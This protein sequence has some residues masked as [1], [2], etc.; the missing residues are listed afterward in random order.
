MAREV[1]RWTPETTWGTFDALATPIIIQLDQ[2]NQFTM[3]KK[4]VEW[5]IRSAGGYNRRVQKGSAKYLLQGA[6]N[7][8]VFDTQLAT[9]APAL[10]ASTSNTLGSAT[11]DHFAVME[12][13]G[14]TKWYGRYLGVM[15]PQVGVAAK[16]S[17]QLMRLTLQMQAKTFATITDSDLPE[18]DATDYPYTNPYVFEHAGA[19]TLATSRSE[20]EDF[21]L[22]IKNMIDFR[23]MRSSTPQ[24]AKYVGRD[25]DFAIRFP[26]IV[27]ADRAAM[28]AQTALAASVTFTN[29][30]NSVEFEFNSN[31][32]VAD[33]TDDLSQDKV[34]MQGISGQCFFDPNAGTPDDLTVTVV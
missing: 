33:V 17:D 24:R 3:R 19:F 1:L 8:L 11:I 21:S 22:T 30:S 28:E 2:S 10:F 12:D 23:F 13:S 26:W 15:C 5:M 9:M 16:E 7:M 31:N 14:S 25:V 4:P 34:F 18:P 27:T 32:Y 20:F 29:G 6:L